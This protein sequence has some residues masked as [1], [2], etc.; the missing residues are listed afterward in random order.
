MWTLPGTVLIVLLHVI[1]S[2]QLDEVESSSPFYRLIN[3]G[4]E[5][6]YTHIGWATLVG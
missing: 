3:W 2:E 5:G 6:I 1:N 4:P